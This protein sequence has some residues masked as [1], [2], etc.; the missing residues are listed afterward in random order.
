M[1]AAAQIETQ[2]TVSAR[3]PALD[4]EVVI[5]GSG[6]SGIGA[7]V[8]LQR[9]GIQDFVILEREDR[10]GGTW[11]Q[12]DYPGL[13]VDMP[14]F[15]YSYPF[16]PK[17]DWS[18]LY[19]PGSELRQYTLDCAEKY[20]LVR[21]T[22]CGEGVSQATYDEDANVW[23][24]EL[25]SGEELVARYL[26]SATGLLV[27]P[28][29]PE[30]EGIDEFEGKIIHTARWDPDYDLTDARVA[31]IGTGAT[32]IQV[33][34]AIADRVKRLDLYQRTPI[35]LMPKPNPELSPGFQRA[36]RVFPFLHTLMRWLANLLVEIALGLGFVRYTRFP[37]I[38]G[39]IERR[40][41]EWIASEVDDPDM[42]EKLTPEYAYFCKRPSFSNTFYKTLNLPHVD[43][44]T[45]P[46]ERITKNS[47]VTAD[48]KEREIDVL[49][50]ATGYNVFN[51]K[52]VP[53]YEIVGRDGRNLGEFWE[54]NRYQAYEG[55][56]V[57]GFPNL[58]LFMGPYSTAGI[59]YFTMI[60]TQ[61]KHMSRCLREARNRG[62]NYIEVRQEAHDRD[63]AKINRRRETTVFFGA[64]CA[65][66]NSYYYDER[67]DTP[68]LRPVTGFEHW[69]NSRFFPMRDYLF[70]RRGD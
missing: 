19:P 53:G 54:Q 45:E 37:W 58:F 35:W 30:I 62:A 43:L 66:S 31:V 67:G 4:H 9:L 32:S 21:R 26:V 13:E 50:C 12:H 60:D 59:S 64:N 29:M 1:S 24:V 70:E 55:A 2:N 18:R 44:I 33:V 10:L 23:R 65:G 68:G 52:C 16:E 28:K 48:G 20:D 22:R 5:V 15:V 36:L 47:I 3:A 41:R 25:E 42:R 14:F 49:I 6:F 40:L 57:P 61:S 8:A 27:I 11:V 7:A 46:I 51:R 34:P 69:L 39:S 38:F 17:S 56:T 63:F